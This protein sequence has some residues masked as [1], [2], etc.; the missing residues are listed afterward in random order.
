MHD[1]IP[2]GIHLTFPFPPPIDFSLFIGFLH[3]FFAVAFF[4]SPVKNTVVVNDR[5]GMDDRCKHGGIFTCDD[6]Y[7]PGTESVIFFSNCNSTYT[8]LGNI[9]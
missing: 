4:F 9:P 1:S 5:W 3:Q 8:V 7:N 2:L 6:R